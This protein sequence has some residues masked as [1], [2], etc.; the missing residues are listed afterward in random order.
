VHLACEVGIIVH[1]QV[2]LQVLWRQEESLLRPGQQRLVVVPPQQCLLLYMDMQ[3]TFQRA[4][5]SYTVCQST[6]LAYL[7][8][9]FVLDVMDT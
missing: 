5:S 6:E 7:R 1:V 2:D 8:V 4:T 3:S 9:V